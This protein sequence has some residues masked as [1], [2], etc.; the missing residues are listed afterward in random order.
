MAQRRRASAEFEQTGSEA[1]PQTLTLDSLVGGYN[2][3]TSPDLLSPQFWAAASQV[4]AGMFG[5]IHRAR[6]APFLNNTATGFAANG[7]RIVSMYAF[8]DLINNV[9]WVI[10]ENNDPAAAGGPQWLVQNPLAPYSFTGGPPVQANPLSNT[11]EVYQNSYPS[12]P[13]SA[14]VLY[15]PMS[16]VQ[17]NFFI[18]QG[19]GL[20]R[21]KIIAS[22]SIANKWPLLEYWGIDAPDVSTQVTLSAGST[23]TIAAAPT[24]AVRALNIVTITTTGAHGL[25]VGNWVSIS[26]VTDTTFNNAAGVAFQI[27][28]VPSGT[29]F[30]Y[31]QVGLASTSGSGTVTFGITKTVGRSYQ[32][33][34]ENVNTAHISAPSP[35]SAYVKYTSQ[36][37]TINCWE[38]GTI[39]TTSG[40]GTVTGVNTAFSPAWVGKALLYSGSGEFAVPP[41][42]T[43]V[44]SPTSMTVTPTVLPG[45]GTAG[46]N[47]QV[48]DPQV[49][50]VRLYAT[51]DAGS[52]Y[53]LIARNSLG[54]GTGT[55]AFSG[56]TFAD[57]ANSEPPNA[58]F[59]SETAAIYNVPP[60]I[61]SF[62]DAY[63]G[64]PIVYGVAAALQTFFYGNIEATVV[65]QPTESFSP[66]NTVTLPLGDG[67]IFGSANLPTGFILWSNRQD[68]FKLTGLL[69]DNTIGTAAQLGATIQRLPYKVGCASPYATAVTPLG[70]I[71]LSSD[72]EVWLFTDHYA[73]KNVGKSVQD[74]LARINGAR[75]PYAKM[76][77]YKRGGHS[78]LTLAISLDSSTFNNK[79]LILDL[80]LLASNGQPSYFTFDMASNAPTWYQYDINCE[81]I[82]TSYDQNSAN[83]LFV[84]DIDLVTDVAWKPGYYTIGKEQSVPNAGVTLHAFGNEAPH[85]IKTVEWMRVLT[86]QIPKNLASQ[87]WRWL[88]NSYDDDAYIIGVNSLVTTL[89]PGVDSTSNPLFLEY[90]PAKFRFGGVRPVKGRRFQIQTVFPSAPG[91]YELRGFE[92]NYTNIVGR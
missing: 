32:Y 2:G 73:P 76:T 48:I 65:G 74:V 43:A 51:A 83:H 72:S 92:V 36:V 52:V 71:W 61:G 67:K 14:S 78:W 84:G 70:V 7:N 82:C 62:V 68:M 20:F 87:G 4:H 10:F 8:Q 44:A 45:Q 56:L 89:N 1:G 16:R 46:L 80:D 55:F 59:G 35:A 13:L 81:G 29:T 63:Q 15:G 34:W 88:I 28:T 24:G 31:S 69:S 38:S 33:A 30:T 79:L 75:L 50:H 5:G 17:I 22:N 85:L 18:F 91:F 40:S 47:F 27:L 21:G 77:Y 23:A 66:L 42:I 3:Y 86:N 26:G 37:G 53:F 57:N 54:T 90:S 58:P 49:T 12:F 39:T 41:I 64:R 60:P 25:S 19:N 11:W 6:W 9:N